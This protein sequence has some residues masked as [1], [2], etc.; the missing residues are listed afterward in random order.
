MSSVE[1]VREMVANG[2]HLFSESPELYVERLGDE[3]VDAV[4]NSFKS[5]KGESWKKIV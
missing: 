3:V 2:Y 1:K 5:Y 4:Y